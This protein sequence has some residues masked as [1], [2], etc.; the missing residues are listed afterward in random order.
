[1]G[2]RETDEVGLL[3]PTRC[4][5]PR[6]EQPATSHLNIP[7]NTMAL[8]LPYPVYTRDPI[9][10]QPRISSKSVFDDVEVAAH[11]LTRLENHPA[12][13]RQVDTER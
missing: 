3:L 4:P 10:S 12:T 13:L 9:Q 2:K 8:S 1:M 5:F 6:K 11:A 7:P